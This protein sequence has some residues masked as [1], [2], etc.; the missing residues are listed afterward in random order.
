MIV[1]I[2]VFRTFLKMLLKSQ[3]DYHT[4]YNMQH[5]WTGPAGA[6]IKQQRT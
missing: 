4:K 6:C 1:Y 2:K 5:E 3:N